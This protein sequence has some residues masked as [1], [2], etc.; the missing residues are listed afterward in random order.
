MSWYSP[1][2]WIGIGVGLGIILKP[3]VQT[4]CTLFK[5]F[6]GQTCVNTVFPQALE[7]YIPKRVLNT[8]E[9][10]KFIYEYLWVKIEQR[11]CHTCVERG[12][13]FHVKCVIQN[14]MYTIVLKPERGPGIQCT[15][16][17]ECKLD[18]TQTILSYIRGVRA[19]VHVLTP[20]KLGYTR[21]IQYLDGKKLSTYEP[22]EPLISRN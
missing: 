15:Y 13:L 18:C 5:T 12:G 9:M 3:T 2:I 8:V 17:T 22:T 1:S 14:K 11:L 10:C 16:E 19:V 6:Q 7:P 20:Y 4:L 21:I